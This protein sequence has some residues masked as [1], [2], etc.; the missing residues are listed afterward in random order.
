M[1]CRAAGTGT[2]FTKMSSPVK[3]GDSLEDLD[4][5]KPCQALGRL[6]SVNVALQESEGIAPAQH[7]GSCITSREPDLA[8]EYLRA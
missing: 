1:R 8:S 2:K 4:G 3:F 5:H 6:M 7:L